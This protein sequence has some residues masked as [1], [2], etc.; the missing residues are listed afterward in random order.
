M[1]T[2]TKLPL[3]TGS[4]TRSMHRTKFADSVNGNVVVTCETV[5]ETRRITCVSVSGFVTVTGVSVA[6]YTAEPDHFLCLFPS[7]FS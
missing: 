2:N 4:V 1:A 7:S 6:G 3:P 5:P